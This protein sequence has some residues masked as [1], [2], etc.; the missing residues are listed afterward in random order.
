MIKCK[1]TDCMRDHCCIE[2]DALMSEG[3]VCDCNIAEDLQ[4]DRDE[5]LKYC[6]FANPQS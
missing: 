2:C 3:N 1:N 4:H 5:I 6:Q